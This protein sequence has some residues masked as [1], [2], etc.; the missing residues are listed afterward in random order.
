MNQTTLS[1]R[2]KIRTLSV[3]CRLYPAT[4]NNNPI[5]CWSIVY[6]AGPSLN[7]YIGSKCLAVAEPP[8]SWCVVDCY[9]RFTRQNQPFSTWRGPRAISSPSSV[10]RSEIN[11]ACASLCTY[12]LNWAKIPPED[13]IWN[14]S[15][16]FS[17]RCDKINELSMRCSRKLFID[18]TCLR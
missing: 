7:P 11:R 1:I 12:R 17:W 14:I 10:T 18:L 3:R 6:D 4:T 5:K 8:P 2:H 16:T 15:I 9:I 13:K